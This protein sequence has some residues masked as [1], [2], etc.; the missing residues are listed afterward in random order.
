[1]TQAEACGY[2]VALARITAARAARLP[3]E[4]RV[5]RFVGRASAQESFD[6]L[7]AE[8]LLK[9]KASL[10]SPLRLL[11]LTHIKNAIA[12]RIEGLEDA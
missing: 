12:S 2:P 5:G 8:V 7:R 6:R 1:M 10:T 9:A 3:V 11:T 4:R